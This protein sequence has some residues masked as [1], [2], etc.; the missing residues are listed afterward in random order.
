MQ[1]FLGDT[2]GQKEPSTLLGKAQGKLRRWGH[3][4]AEGFKE[5]HEVK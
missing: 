2:Q 3:Q 5:I 4:E 1:L